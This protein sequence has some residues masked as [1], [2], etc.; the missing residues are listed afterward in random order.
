MDFIKFLGTAG[1]RFAVTQQIRKSG[2]I[3]ISLDETNVLLDPGP[4]SLLRCLA[5]RPKLKPTSLD[6]I[7]LSHRHIDH[8]ND[9]NIMI[10]AMTN[11][12]K[13]KRGKVFAPSDALDDDPV[14]LHHFRNHVQEIVV[15]KEN[16]TYT[17]NNLHLSTPVSHVHDVETYGINI[18]GEKQSISYIADTQFFPEIVK[19]YQGDILIANVVLLSSK[20][21]VNHLSVEDMKQIILKNQPKLTVLTHFGMTMIRAKPWEIAEKLSEETGCKVIAASDGL[22]IDLP[23]NGK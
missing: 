5:S 8:S 17:L 1:A 4:G 9:I 12:G 23:I 22:K 19:H 10:E 20:S 13:T 16:H 2:G 21:V 6:A 3:W 18:K 7:M 11:G 14:I 15:L